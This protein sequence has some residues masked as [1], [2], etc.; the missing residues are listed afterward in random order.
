MSDLSIPGLL[1]I[2]WYES[3][4]GP[5]ARGPRRAW[6]SKLK[7]R[8]LGG[9][10]ARAV[11]RGFRLDRVPPAYG[12][13]LGRSSIALPMSAMMANTPPAARVFDIG[14]PIAR[15][16]LSRCSIPRKPAILPG[17]LASNE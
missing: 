8:R 15:I 1:R 13:P 9:M 17:R 14:A 2:V 12:P 5:H 10:D 4:Y 6:T 11:G 7:P 3:L 16:G